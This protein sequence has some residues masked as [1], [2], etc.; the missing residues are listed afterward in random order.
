MRFTKPAKITALFQVAI[1]ALIIAV[2]CVSLAQEKPSAATANKEAEI[3]FKQGLEAFE[4]GDFK[5]AIDSFTTAINLDDK[6]A[7]AYYYRSRVRDEVLWFK[8]YTRIDDYTSAIKLNPN[9]ADAYLRL[10]LIHI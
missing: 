4:K 10:S 7:E 2:P 8:G 1:V 9:H 6:F 5:G 3:A